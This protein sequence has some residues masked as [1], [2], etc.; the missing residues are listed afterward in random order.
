MNPFKSDEE[1]EPEQMWDIFDA[2][3]LCETPAVGE[4]S[5][6]TGVDFFEIADSIEG[7]RLFVLIIYDIVQP[8]RLAKFAKFLQG[9]GS[10]VQKSAFE[11]LLTQDKYDKLLTE[12]PH[13]IEKEDNVRIYR[14][15]GKGQITAW[16]SVVR[17][18][19]EALVII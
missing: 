13:Y 10:R 2:D 8:K 11:A 5:G 4:N 3:D 7:K 18:E 16:G 15:M 12:I 14:I 1:H 9:Y 19:A 6:E 17:E